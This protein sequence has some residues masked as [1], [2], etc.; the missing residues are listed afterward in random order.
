MPNLKQFIEEKKKEF[1]KKMS[2]WFQPSPVSFMFYSKIQ[3]FISQALTECAEETI[4]AV[5]K[6]K[7][8]FLKSERGRMIHENNEKKVKFY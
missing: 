8:P 7:T 6:E 4:K 3:S 5:E 2:G 1:D